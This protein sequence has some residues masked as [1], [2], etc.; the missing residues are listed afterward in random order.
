MGAPSFE[1][2]AHELAYRL[3]GAVAVGHNATFDGRFIASELRRCGKQIMVPALCTIDLQQQLDPGSDRLRLRS[4]AEK[5]GVAI[6]APHSALGD[7]RV[8][9]QLLCAQLHAARHWGRPHSITA[10]VAPMAVAMPAEVVQ[11]KI[12]VGSMRRGDRGWLAGVIDRLPISTNS[13]LGDVAEMYLSLLG[14][15]LADGKVTREEAEQVA[16]LAGGAG[17]NANQVA[18]LNRQFLDSLRDTALEDGVLTKQEITSLNKAAAA[19]GEADYFSDLEATPATRAA[20]ERT[21]PL[22][23]TRIVIV[24]DGVEATRIREAA[25]QAGATLA[26]NVTKTVAAVIDA[27][28]TDTDRKLVRAR[29]LGIGILSIDEALQ[30]FGLAAVRPSPATPSEPTV[31][32][33]GWY[34]DPTSRH[35]LRYWD[36]AAWSTHVAD[37]GAVAT[38]PL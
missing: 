11:P 10:P 30:E 3:S 18:A 37:A 38:D 8:V 24:G 25:R 4:A 33:A 26:I 17:M 9:S 19:V 27:T 32:P 7:A 21:G 12:R 15:V 28:E 1:L 23:G 13:E 14:E 35:E 29:E 2:I 22:A 31:P 16:R 36:G 5:Y 20:G 34:R 6:D